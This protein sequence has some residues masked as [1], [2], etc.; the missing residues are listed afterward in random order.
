[1][2][3]V[4]VVVCLS[5][6]AGLGCGVEGIG[7]ATS[8][9]EI[10]GIRLPDGNVFDFGEVQKG[11]V[12]IAKFRI[13]NSLGTRVVFDPSIAKS[14]GCTEARLSEVS[15]APGEISELE[16]KLTASNTGSEDKAVVAN[17][18]VIKPFDIPELTFQLR[19]K[20]FREFQ[21]SPQASN[22]SGFP[23]DPIELSFVVSARRG[24]QAEIGDIVTDIPGATVEIASDAEEDGTSQE[25]RV[26]ATLAS[27]IGAKNRTLSVPVNSGNEKLDAEIML[28]VRSPL[29]VAPAAVVLSSKSSEENATLVTVQVA[30][31]SFC[32][33]EEEV[34][35]LGGPDGCE[36]SVVP[37]H[38][39]D[40]KILKAQIRFWFKGASSVDEDS[41]FGTLSIGYASNKCS[42]NVLLPVAYR[43]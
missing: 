14:C 4:N 32:I 16:M 15:L 42:G 34:H 17:V 31:E 29:I 8:P 38:R 5:L 39:A 36:F 30:D 7:V 35:L 11:S 28:D 19:Y 18:E 43:K 22:A 37:L 6:L 21:I 26:L 10:N 3:W 13:V 40:G 41:Q 33:D 24:K 23:G 9:Q 2:R 12:N 20:C 25:I 1:M 27:E